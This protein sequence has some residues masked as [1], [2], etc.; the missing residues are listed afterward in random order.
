MLLDEPL[1]ALDAKMRKEM[2]AELKKIQKE[3]GITFIYVTHDIHTPNV[4]I[5]NTLLPLK[6]IVGATIFKIIEM[7]LYIPVRFYL[8]YLIARLM[9]RYTPRLLALLTG[10][11]INRNFLKS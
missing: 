7:I 10:S 2:Q 4:L 5:L 1:G 3:V 6:S 9:Q 11:R 8:C